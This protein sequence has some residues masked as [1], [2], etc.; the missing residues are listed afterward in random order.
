M[1]TQYNQYYNDELSSVRMTS[2]YNE[3]QSIAYRQA[4][5]SSKTKLTISSWDKQ[6]ENHTHLLLVSSSTSSSSHVTKDVMALIIID[7]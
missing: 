7:K 1:W 3:T 6:K 4:K 5:L 2:V